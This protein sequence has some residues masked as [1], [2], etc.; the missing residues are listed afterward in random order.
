[1]KSKTSARLFLFSFLLAFGTTVGEPAS[2]KARPD[3]AAPDRVLAEQA[4]QIDALI[5]AEL[6]E[7]RIAPASLT[8]DSVFLRRIYLDAV[9]RIPTLEEART[10]LDSAAA[11]KRRR[12]IDELL[13]SEGRV[14]REYNYWADLLRI[15]TRMPNV[16]GRPYQ[17]WIK[18]AVRENLPYD[19]FVRE[20]ITAE[21]YIWD[22]GAA[23]YYLR[24]AGM[25]LDHMANTFQTFLGTQL[26]C[27]QCHDHPTDDFTQ[28]DYY[29]QAAYVFGVKTSDRRMGQIYRQVNNRTKDSEAVA[30]EVRQM[31]RRLIRPLRN[32]VNDTQQKLKLPDDYQYAD[33]RPKSV[34]EPGVIFGKAIEVEQGENLRDGY[35]RWLTSADNPRFARVIA[36]RL[37]KRAM[38]V[39]LIEPVDDLSDGY[40]ASHP[41]LMDYL[42]QL[43]IDLDFDLRAYMRVLYH[44]ETYQR[45]VWPEEWEEGT[46]YHF[47]GR[48]LQRLSAEQLWDSLA[49]LIVPDLDRRPGAVA[50]DRRLEGAQELIGMSADQIIERARNQMASEKLRRQ[51]SQQRLRLNRLIKQARANQDKEELGRLQK[52][53][54]ELAGDGANSAG[55][56]ARSDRDKIRNT[57]RQDSRWKD[58]P[59]GLVRASELTSPAPPGHF[60]R[61]FGQSDRETIE[62][63]NDEANVPQILTLL[64]GPIHNYMWG[65]KSLLRAN[66]GTVEDPERQL[67]SAFLTVLTRRPTAEESEWLLPMLRRHRESALKDIVWTL[68]NTKQFVF[69]Q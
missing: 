59:A 18:S 27:A 6:Q 16:P 49:G 55:R 48:R 53:L 25:P 2:S 1:M 5:E 20:L 28:M 3:S 4:G 35:A 29:R 14:S 67:E 46:A 8:E 34:V 11:D 40:E 24:D 47:A 63:A 45:N 17:E 36:N 44:T 21:G 12:L 10:F 69:V 50:R 52:R 54:R 31:A 56:T 51:Q 41:E 13:S 22:K 7:R 9:G 62:N 37:W 23:G 43:V 33:A 39:G 64:N 30:P 38:G 60:L 57:Q 32:R 61:Q 58:I 19:Q 15:K 68:V 42:T 65:A 26:V 66:V